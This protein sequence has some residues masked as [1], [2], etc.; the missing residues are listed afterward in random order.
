MV[1][2]DVSLD[3]ETRTRMEGLTQ[4]VVA[5]ASAACPG[6]PVQLKLTK[7]HIIMSKKYNQRNPLPNPSNDF[8]TK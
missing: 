8:L 6:T 3:E 1:I 5:A 7:P 4:A 2:L